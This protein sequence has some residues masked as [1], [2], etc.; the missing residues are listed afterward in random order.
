M[1]LLPIFDKQKACELIQQHNIEAVTIVPLMLYRILSHDPVALRSLNCIISGGAALD[2]KLVEETHNKLGPVLFNLYG[3]SEAGV[4]IMAT[5]ADLKYAPNTIGKAIAGA[6]IRLLDA[7]NK[8][9]TDGLIG[10]ICVNSKWAVKNNDIN[11]IETGDLGYRDKAGYYY[12]CGKMD[13]RIV[14]GGENVYPAELENI[15][16]KHRDIKHAAVIG[17]SDDEFG[18]RLKAFIVPADNSNL[19]KKEIHHWL[20][21]RAARF[22][23]PKHIEFLEELPYTA[24]GKPDKKGLR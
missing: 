2:V 15:L 6:T 12:L 11:W 24:L 9:V 10:R 22:Q 13:D 1:F 8:E 17:I 21:T 20:S 7:D 18:Q 4:C 19:H 14:S 5:P 3:T 23:M 16:M